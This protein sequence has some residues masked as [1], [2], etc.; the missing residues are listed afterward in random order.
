M[1]TSYMKTYG[2]L[3]WSNDYGPNIK[4]R[5]GMGPIQEG[6]RTEGHE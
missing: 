1:L 3:N 5:I 4:C 2:K 6:E